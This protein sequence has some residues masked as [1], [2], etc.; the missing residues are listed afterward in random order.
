VS[1]I[2]RVT[3]YSADGTP[4]I[5][6][7][8]W[9][10]DGAPGVAV[11]HG[12]DSRR[13]NHRDMV[14]RL[15]AAGMNAASVDLR[16]HGESEGRLDANVIDDVLAV[17]DL[18]VTRGAG[19]LGVRGSSLGGFLALHAAVRH[20]AVRAVVAICPAHHEG[21]A[22]H[23]PRLEWA[24]TM[25]LEDAVSDEDGV[26]RGY[27]HARGDEIVPWQWS[28]LLHE[29]SPQPKRLRVAMGGHHRSMQ[30]DPDV[31]ADG[32]AFLAE[33]LGADRGEPT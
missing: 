16:G 29:L 1:E 33:H 10:A 7:L 8:A 28:L 6:D 27:W 2:E 4:L 25:S 11:V 12:L 15:A 30:H 19:P 3:I 17:L 5:A 24:R 9:V 20:P 26:A 18:L 22:D 32:V 21:L 23:G 14:E 31:Q 13:A